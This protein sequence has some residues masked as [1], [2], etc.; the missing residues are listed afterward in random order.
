MD[1]I[2]LFS[3]SVRE[4]PAASGFVLDFDGTLSEI[5]L[6][7]AEA[8]PVAGASEVLAELAKNYGLVALVSGRRA[9]FL[10]GLVDA[11][12]VRYIGVYG[13]EEFAGGRLVHPPEADRWRGTASRLARDAEA[14]ITT[15]G[16]TGCEVEYKE[17]AV[18]LHFRAAPEH[19]G[20][21]VDWA[22]TVAPRRN[23]Q[24]NLGRMVV[25]L[26]PARVSKAE[27]LRRLIDQS[28]VRYL[29]AA[30]DDHADVEALLAAKDILGQQAITVGVASNEEPPGLREASDL[31]VSSP[32][33]VVAVLGEF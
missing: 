8:S 21:L 5:V 32:A 15:E 30:G 1:P 19:G 3:K 20:L 12:G 11:E 22:Q 24:A 7:A 26:R 6:D 28:G 31:V 23:F 10:A 16:L 4:D 13:A 25:E 29:L 17:L 9:E 14:L 27:T 33:E 2:H 18:S